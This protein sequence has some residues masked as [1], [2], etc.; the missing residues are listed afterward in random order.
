MADL[1]ICETE[2]MKGS[3]SQA[4]CNNWVSYNSYMYDHSSHCS[5]CF[6]TNI[7]NYFLWSFARNGDSA[8]QGKSDLGNLQSMIWEFRR[9]SYQDNVVTAT[10]NL[11]SGEYTWQKDR[12][13]TKI[14]AG[15][16]AMM[17]VCFSTSADP[18]AEG[19]SCN[20]TTANI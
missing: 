4:N 3:N 16:D 17:G 10:L 12:T 8:I 5:N 11:V 2:V 6:T 13:E 7:F 14:R 19:K 1:E 18:V 15:Y 20:P 9:K